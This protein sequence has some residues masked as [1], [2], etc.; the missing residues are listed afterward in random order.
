MS[1]LLRSLVLDL[2]CLDQKVLASS[3]FLPSRFVFLSSQLQPS[4]QCD[5]VKT[6][7][8]KFHYMYPILCCKGMILQRHVIQYFPH[9]NLHSRRKVGATGHCL[10]SISTR[11]LGIPNSALVTQKCSNPVSQPISQPARKKRKVSVSDF[12]VDK[13]LFFE[14]F[15][16]HGISIFAAR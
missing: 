13:I 6:C 1:F 8:S 14:S 5:C 7:A 2:A 4:E 12:D 3:R 11:K 16:S 15:F 10:C 9:H